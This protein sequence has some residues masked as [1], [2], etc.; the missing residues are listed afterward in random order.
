MAELSKYKFSQEVIS[1]GEKGFVAYVKATYP[2][3]KSSEIKELKEMV[4]G[5]GKESKTES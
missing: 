1:R 5:N 2:K 3:L 4:Y